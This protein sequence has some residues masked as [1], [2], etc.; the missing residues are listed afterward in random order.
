[1]QW[2]KGLIA[3]W[4]VTTFLLV[5]VVIVF[6]VIKIQVDTLVEQ[7]SELCSK[8]APSYDYFKDPPTQ[9]LEVWVYNISNPGLFLSGD[10]GA[11]LHE[12]GPYSFNLDVSVF[13]NI[14]IKILI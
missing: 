11:E 14:L 2:S 9:N 4:A 6:V 13:S 3:T 10:A 7:S 8:N 1:M 5:G 12:K